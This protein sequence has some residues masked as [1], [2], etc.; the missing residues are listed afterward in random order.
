MQTSRSSGIDR[1]YAKKKT[2]PTQRDI[3]KTP[4]FLYRDNG[5]EMDTTIMGYS[6]R[7]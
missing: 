5:N 4:C 6:V 1:N 2:K 7:V 3:E